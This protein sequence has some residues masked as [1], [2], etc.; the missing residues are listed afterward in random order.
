M[1]HCCERRILPKLWDQLI[2]PT[3]HFALDGQLCVFAPTLWTEVATKRQ[4][5]TFTALLMTGTHTE[6]LNKGSPY[7]LHLLYLLL[8]HWLLLTPYW[9]KAWCPGL[10]LRRCCAGGSLSRWRKSKSGAVGIGKCCVFVTFEGKKKH[11]LL[12]EIKVNCGL[13][14]DFKWPA[15]NPWYPKTSFFGLSKKKIGPLK[16]PLLQHILGLSIVVIILQFFE[17]DNKDPKESLQ[18]FIF[19]YLHPTVCMTVGPCPSQ[20]LWTHPCVSGSIRTT[21]WPGEVW[22]AASAALWSDPHPGWRGMCHPS[23]SSTPCTRAPPPTVRWWT[24]APWGIW[25][26]VGGKHTGSTDC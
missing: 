8:R 26:S 18:W 22:R 11:K 24:P 9:T 25:A 21:N 19:A 4:T 3:A 16:L 5:W 12:I 23:P 15:E 13:P 6:W 2:G 20:W 14:N 7:F 1:S 10:S 17:S